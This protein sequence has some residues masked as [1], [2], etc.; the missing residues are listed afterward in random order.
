MRLSGVVR[1]KPGWLTGPLIG[2]LL[3]ACYLIIQPAPVYAVDSSVGATVCGPGA[4]PASIDIT[5]PND[6]SV[7]DQASV[8]FRGNV[9]NATQIDIDVDGQY[10]TTLAVGSNQT[11]FE[12]DLTLTEGTHTVT[13]TAN[14]LCGGQN[15]DD[16][17]VITYQPATDPSSGGSTPTEVDG[18]PNV[19][20]ADEQIKDSEIA[21][22]IEKLPIIGSAI[23]VVADFV[24]A[25]GLEATVSAGNVTVGVA[26]VGLT[27]AALT[28]VVMASTLAPVA[29]QALPG[30]SEA[31]N[32]T[33]HRS[34]IYLGWIIRG[35]GILTMAI[36]YFL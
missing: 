23:S 26:R 3:G 14:A 27:V 28:S 29:A 8:T 5:E 33:S 20:P 4:P 15:D 12:N 1:N 2:L 6:D 11:T 31:F 24:N 32:V 36:A 25:T 22:R 10:V 19:L 35:V 7:V 30:V 16:S 34:M 13:M 21:Q 18:E 17:V 9:G